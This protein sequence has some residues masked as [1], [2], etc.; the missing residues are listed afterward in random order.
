MTVL[1][2][3]DRFHPAKA[4]VERVPSLPAMRKGFARFVESK[5]AEH[6]AYIQEN[7]AD[8]PEIRNW[9]WLASPV[10]AQ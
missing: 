10:D 8:L 7:G 5:L 9:R 3:L 2:R 1:N 6:D 4:V